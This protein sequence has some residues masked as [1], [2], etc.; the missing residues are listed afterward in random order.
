MTST[1][2]P[3]DHV[4]WYGYVIRANMCQQ[5]AGINRIL[6]PQIYAA[7]DTM[8]V[9]RICKQLK[10]DDVRD[11]LGDHIG[12]EEVLPLSEAAE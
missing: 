11:A 1:L 8:Y 3:C 7:F 4:C 5:P 9:R 2:Q 12:E 6:K 10:F